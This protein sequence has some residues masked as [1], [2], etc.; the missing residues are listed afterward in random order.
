MPETHDSLRV[1]QIIARLNIG[2]P[3]IYV[4]LVTG[5]LNAHGHVTHL[6][7]GQVGADE[8]DMIYYAEQRGVEPVIVPELGRSIHPLRDIATTYKLYRM[9]RQFKPDVVHTHTAKAGFTGRVAA[10][11]A[12]V[13]VIVHTFHG[14]VFSGYF[15]PA[16]TQIFLWLERIAARMSDTII[17]L[18]D[19]LKRELASEYNITS[20]ENIAILPLGLD[21]APF[22]DT[23]RHQTTFRAAHKI[24][25]DVPL[26]GIVGRLVPVKNHALFFEAAARIHA[27]RPDVH[28]A[29]IGD[30]ETRAELEAQVDALGLR[31]VTMF[32]GWQQDLPP[33]YSDLNVS[34]I[35]SK[36]EGTPVSVIESLA[37][38]CP[39]VATAVGGLPDLL[40]NG[41][42]GQLVAPGDASALADAILDTLANPPETGAAQSLMLER[43]GVA[44]LVDDL[45]T[46]YRTLLKRKGR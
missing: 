14:H 15:S 9:I 8:G 25:P 19:G 11:L 13:P 37:A 44:R 7:T 21:L 28:F 3:A 20:Y 34:V 24:P 43:Y 36:N 10:W 27:Q 12:R 1:M 2:G 42:L 41:D 45:E 26:V 30:G 16:K 35:S 4:T 31:D 22:V 46:L 32:T 5:A 38:G 39:V 6:I 23:P 40:D 33:I 29:V 17:T 18:T